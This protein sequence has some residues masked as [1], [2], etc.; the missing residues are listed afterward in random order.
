MLRRII[1]I[2]LFLI[3]LGIGNIIVG[4]LKGA[5]YEA[6]VEELAQIGRSADRN[7]LI[8]YKQDH[9]LVNIERYRHLS[10]NVFQ[11]Q[12]KAVMRRDL[13]RVVSFGGKAVLAFG[14]II[15]ILG[16]FAGLVY[17]IT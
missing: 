16:F 5:Q 10:Q 12:Q 8:P 2:G 7:P 4:E 15:V 9:P 14:V 6:V 1:L 17:R 11:R 13:Y 3:V